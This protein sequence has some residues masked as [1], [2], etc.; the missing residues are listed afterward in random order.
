MCPTLIVQ[1]G[2]QSVFYFFGALGI[3]WWAAWQFLTESTPEQSATIS[4]KEKEYIYANRSI[5]TKKKI[6]LD[7]VPW[8]LLLSEKATWAIIIAHFCVTW[9]SYLC[10]IFQCCT[11]TNYVF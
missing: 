3:F 7:G 2:W 11:T 9:G 6:G 1:F 5:S 4:E 10:P 8:K